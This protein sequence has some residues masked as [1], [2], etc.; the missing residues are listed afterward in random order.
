MYKYS[1]LISSID[2][3]YK[4][5]RMGLY[6]IILTASVKHLKDRYPHLSSKIDYLNGK[7]KSK[8][9][10]WIVYQLDKGES[11]E[12]LLRYIELFDRKLP[13]LSVENRDISRV[14]SLA[15]LKKVLNDLENKVRRTVEV[16]D[17]SAKKL[18]E[19]GRYVLI[20]PDTKLAACSFGSGTKWCV[21]SQEVPHYENYINHNV[22]I[23]YLI[24]K[25][26]PSQNILYK[27]A[28]AVQRD[29]DNNVLKIEAFDATDKI[30]EPEDIA[31]YNLVKQ[32]IIKDAEA[33]PA[34]AIVY[35][36]EGLLSLE[37]FNH[38]MSVAIDVGAY[39]DLSS[40]PEKYQQIK[41]QTDIFSYVMKHNI[42]YNQKLQVY[43]YLNDEFKL[44]LT[45]KETDPR[46]LAKLAKDNDKYVRQAVAENKN[47][48][49]ETL[50]LLAR[51]N[52]KYIRQSV[53]ANNNTSAETLALL[54]R[55]NDVSVREYVAENNNTSPATLALLAKD[56]D[57]NVRQNVAAN[58]NTSAETLA[59]LARD[60]DVSVR[61][62]VAKNHNTHSEIFA[63]LAKDNYEIIRQSV[64]EHNNTSPEILDLLAKDNNT[65]VRQ[66]VAANNNTSK[67][68]LDLLA[69]NNG[70]FVKR[71]VAKNNNTS[72]ETLVLLA[73]DNDAIVR[74][75]VAGNNN[76][77]PETLALLAKDRD[78]S[79]R[80]HVAKNN[81]TS[82]ETLSL[83]YKDYDED[84]RIYV[85]ANNNT[86]TK[87]LF[88]LA[89]SNS[90]Y[91]KTHLALNSNMS[92]EILALLAKD[93]YTSIRQHVAEHNNT[94]PATLA[95]LAKDNDVHVRQNVARNNNTSPETLDLLAKDNEVSVRRLVAAN[96]NTST[97][98]LAL[99]AKDSDKDVRQLVA[100]NNNVT[101]EILALIDEYE[102]AK[103]KR[104]LHPREFPKKEIEYDNNYIINFGTEEQR[105][106]F[107]DSNPPINDLKLLAKHFN[108]SYKVQLRLLYLNND[109]I[110]E[111]LLNNYT[112]DPE[113]KKIILGGKDY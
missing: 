49:A 38:F 6:S 65:Y 78:V 31:G 87:I 96:N 46:V 63:L 95:L 111:I 104:I 67:E 81:N 20:R 89:K 74:T 54:A 109:E 94:S 50:A 112:V 9:L 32:I 27:V 59:L 93:K 43:K 85:A 57:L 44:V 80:Q 61:E 30:Y 53:A 1:Q 21:T 12:E 68:T 69:K 47:T 29:L 71:N 15:D 17:E 18:F 13:A 106:K 113:I 23:Y 72:Q 90:I 39:F 102:S 82:K 5:S 92:P 41:K 35:A 40:F 48:S 75:N 37:E 24:D 64:A 45:E 51:D 22:V 36:M 26:L 25:T 16:K 98:T 34:G 97:A 77:S 79:V 108:I 56:N 33:F 110:D 105:L 62:Y 99:L 83:L 86:P 66:S 107:I 14:N 7:V 52:G 3:F 73:K 58:N 101:P 8:Y 91:V 88:L 42:Q 55:D 84:V 76:T 100:K 70:V 28:F 11:Q 2:N 103:P 60:N 10:D 19:N 4:I